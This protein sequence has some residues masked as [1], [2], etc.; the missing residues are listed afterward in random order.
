MLLYIDEIQCS[1]IFQTGHLVE[2]LELGTYI[3]T[4]FE[5]WNMAFKSGKMLLNGATLHMSRPRA[6]GHA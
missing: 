2:A 6:L 5:S 3:W 1:V 4:L